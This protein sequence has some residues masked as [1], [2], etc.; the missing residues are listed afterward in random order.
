MV[1]VLDLEAVHFGFESSLVCKLSY[2]KLMFLK[3]GFIFEH[4]LDLKPVK[5]IQL[6]LE[7]CVEGTKIF[8]SILSIYGMVHSILIRF[9]TAHIGI[10]GDYIL[11]LV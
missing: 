9:L 3:I 7:V 6:H 10:T 5:S 11:P 1:K 4:D 2:F 8:F